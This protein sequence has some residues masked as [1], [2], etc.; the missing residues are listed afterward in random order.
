[1][2]RPASPKIALAALLAPWHARWSQLEARQRRVLAA[3]SGLLAI[4][5]F[6]ALVW[7]PLERA[8]STLSV[9]VPALETTRGRL[10]AQAEEVKRLRTLP[11]APGGTGALPDLALLRTRFAGAEVTSQPG[12]GI[13]LVAT[14]TRFATWLAAL[15]TFNGSLQVADLTV[16]R[17]P[18]PGERVRLEALLIPAQATPNPGTPR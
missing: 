5:L 11:P 3:G 13:R 10:Q 12:G 6:G 1:M 16:N 15:R 14:D 4:A 8:R 9:Q 18:G 17:L 2:R 7:L